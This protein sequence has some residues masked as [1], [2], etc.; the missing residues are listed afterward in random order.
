MK[1]TEADWHKAQVMVRQWLYSSYGIT[2][3]HTQRRQSPFDLFTQLGT[4]IE[5]KHAS[6]RSKIH[7]KGRNGT[8]TGWGFNIHRHGTISQLTDFYILVCSSSPELEQL[9]FSRNVYLVIPAVLMTATTLFITL[10]SMLME[11]GRYA[12][13]VAALKDFDNT[14][15]PERLDE[16][17]TLAFSPLP[18][19]IQLIGK[20]RYFN[21]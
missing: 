20:G 17:I 7:T 9:D 6:F 12:N 2:T 18:T 4:R 16:T 13:A 19:P 3:R 8:Q 11:Y 14:C 1:E 10:R 5:V 21:S 15:L